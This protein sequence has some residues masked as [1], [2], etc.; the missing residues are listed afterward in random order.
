MYVHATYAYSRCRVRNK[1]KTSEDKKI[2]YKRERPERKIA[3]GKRA[4][5]RFEQR[6]GTRRGEDRRGRK[7]TARWR[8]G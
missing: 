2:K 8:R 3:R 5:C 7:T 6:A 1:D 4:P